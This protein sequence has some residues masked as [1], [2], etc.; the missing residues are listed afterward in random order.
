MVIPPSP[1]RGGLPAPGDAAIADVPSA[2]QHRPDQTLLDRAWTGARADQVSILSRIRSCS[3]RRWARPGGC[4]TKTCTTG[5]ALGRPWPPRAARLGMGR[6]ARAPRAPPIFVAAVRE[7]I[8][9]RIVGAW[10][11]VID[12]APIKARRR[13][14]R[15]AAIGHAPAQHPTRFLR[16]FRVHTLLCR[17]RNRMG[18]PERP[19]RA[20]CRPPSIN[21][22]SLWPPVWTRPARRPLGC[23]LLGPRPDPLV[24]RHRRRGRRRAP[25]TPNAAGSTPAC[26][27][28]GRSTN[29]A[30]APASSPSS[31]APSASSTCNARP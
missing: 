2:A 11:L 9:R 5:S 24:P 6:V 4:A 20:A 13:H 19:G 1:R 3:S 15:D 26:R 27:P 21:A 8:R 17:G 7:A 22:C 31:S 23:R 30:N 14:D 18:R 10:D 29:S 12:S 28:P 16:S 25:G